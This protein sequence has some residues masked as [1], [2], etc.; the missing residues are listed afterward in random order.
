MGEIIF[1]IFGYANIQFV[2]NNIQVNPA[3]T[4]TLIIPFMYPS[5][6]SH[7]CASSNV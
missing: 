7:I 2:L 3:C 6:F 1:V 4:F 5:E